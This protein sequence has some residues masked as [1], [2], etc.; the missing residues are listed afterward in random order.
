[1]VCD[2]GL[3]ESL[4]VRSAGEDDDPLS[5]GSLEYAVE[6][7]GFKRH[8]SHGRSKLRSS[9]RR[10]RLLAE[11]GSSTRWKAIMQK[12]RQSTVEYGLICELL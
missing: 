12:C 9:N 7:L 1:M 2:V 10:L 11:R 3:G 4:V 8:C 5:I 6:H